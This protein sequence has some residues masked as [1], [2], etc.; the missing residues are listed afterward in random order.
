MGVQTQGASAVAAGWSCLAS[1]EAEADRY[2][3][4]LGEGEA[5]H[6]LASEGAVGAR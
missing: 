5:P 3:G 1:G 2:R 6:C 4:A